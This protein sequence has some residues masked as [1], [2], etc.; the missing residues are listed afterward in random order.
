MLATSY[1][2]KYNIIGKRRQIKKTKIRLEIELVG[3]GIQ[4][5][6]LLYIVTER[7]DQNKVQE[8]F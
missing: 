1:N 7:E 2:Q 4:K 8:K 3:E 6:K 5:T